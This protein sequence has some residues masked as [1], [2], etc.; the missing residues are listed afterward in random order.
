MSNSMIEAFYAEREFVSLPKERPSA[1]IQD[2]P[3]TD[4]MV[5][6]KEKKA[7]YILVDDNTLE[8]NPDFVRSIASLGLEE[9]YRLEDRKGNLTVV[10]RV[11]R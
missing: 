3:G 6:A 7:D 4:V 11:A 1:R 5:Y 9:I 10:Y 8:V 2:R